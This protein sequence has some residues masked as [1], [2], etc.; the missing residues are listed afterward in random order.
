MCRAILPLWNDGESF[1][2]LHSAAELEYAFA[3][4]LLA[5]KSALIDSFA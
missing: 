3:H 2:V 5:R 1:E 4:A